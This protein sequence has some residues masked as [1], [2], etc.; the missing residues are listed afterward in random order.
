MRV[1]AN[2]RLGGLLAVFTLL[3]AGCVGGDAGVSQNDDEDLSSVQANAETLVD[4]GSLHGSVVDDSIQP[5]EHATVALTELEVQAVTG[6]DGRFAIENVAPGAYTLAAVALGYESVAR[7]VEVRASEVTEVTL[8]MRPIPVVEAY[9]EVF[10]PFSGYFEC[11]LGTPTQTGE[12]GWVSVLAHP[13]FLYPNDRSIF[14]FNMTSEDWQTFQGEMRWSQ[15]TLAT[16]TSMRLAFSYEK[17]TGVHRWC[18][19]EGPNPLHWRLEKAGLDVSKCDEVG[20][21]AE[22]PEPK[23]SLNPLRTYA[24]VPFG[25]T[26][27]PVY[28]SVQQRFQ[29]MVS[30]F[31]GEPAPKDYFAFPDR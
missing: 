1:P 11:R 16:S 12:C 4:A 19:G 20:N 15:G 23:P 6:P 14:R 26:S 2:A 3:L 30:A 13:T 22:A 28:L 8:S 9:Y 10:G 31:Y 18:S 24:N 21:N 27:S 17:R 29:V 7:R 25:S 5:I